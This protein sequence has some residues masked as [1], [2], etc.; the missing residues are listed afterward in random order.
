MH[1]Q[2]EIKI[3]KTKKSDNKTATTIEKKVVLIF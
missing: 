3:Y 2:S 1:K